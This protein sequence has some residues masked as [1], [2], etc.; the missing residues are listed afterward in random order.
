M[1]DSNIPENRSFKKIIVWSLAGLLVVGSIGYFGFFASGDGFQGLIKRFAP[2]VTTQREPVVEI[3]T[4]ETET[5]DIRS[6]SKLSRTPQIVGQ[7]CIEGKKSDL[8]VDSITLKD[9][10]ESMNHN[11][12]DYTFEVQISNVNKLTNKTGVYLSAYDKTLLDGIEK[13]DQINKGNAL[14]HI[15]VTNSGSKLI[16]DCGK[17]YT[18]EITVP[19]EKNRTNTE[20][21]F[22]IDTFNVVDEENEGS[23]SNTFSLYSNNLKAYTIGQPYNSFTLSDYTSNDGITGS[24]NAQVTSLETQSEKDIA[25]KQYRYKVGVRNSST[26]SILNYEDTYTATESLAFAKG[27]VSEDVASG[28]AVEIYDL[29]Q[30]TGTNQYAGSVEFNPEANPA[31]FLMLMKP[32]GQYIPLY[33]YVKLEAEEPV[34]STYCPVSDPF[35]LPNNYILIEPEKPLYKEVSPE[36]TI[37]VEVPVSTFN[38]CKKGSNP[39][40]ITAVKF[41]Q[42][43]S[44]DTGQSTVTYRYKMDGAG[45]WDPVVVN[46][47][48][49][50][51][52][53]NYQDIKLGTAKVLNGGN[54]SKVEVTAS[55][56]ANMK[57]SQFSIQLLETTTPV[58]FLGADDTYYQLSTDDWYYSVKAE[59]IGT[60]LVYKPE[61]GFILTWD[62]GAEKYGY[63]TSSKSDES[64]QI[65]NIGFGTPLNQTANIESVDLKITTDSPAPENIEAITEISPVTTWEK[66]Y[67]GFISIDPNETLGEAITIP[68]NGTVTIPINANIP[69]GHKVRLR[70]RINT[71]IEYD[72]KL[73]VELV[74]VNSDAPDAN[75]KKSGYYTFNQNYILYGGPLELPLSNSMIFVM[76]IAQDA[77]IPYI[78]AYISQKEPLSNYLTWVSFLNF[79]EFPIFEIRLQATI[80]IGYDREITVSPVV[81]DIIGNF[82]DPIEF[83][84]ARNEDGVGDY[85]EMTDVSVGEPLL[86]NFPAMNK[87]N[88]S[89]IVWGY[90]NTYPD[91]ESVLFK[92]IVKPITA[93]DDS[94]LEIPVYINDYDEINDPL[95]ENDYPLLT[96]LFGKEKLIQTDNNNSLMQKYLSINQIKDQEVDMNNTCFTAQ[97]HVEITEVTYTHDAHD[98]QPFQNVMLS[99]YSNTIY[100]PLQGWSPTK[101]IFTPSKPVTVYNGGS[102]CLNMKVQSPKEPLNN[103]FFDLTG[104][105][106]KV[107]DSETPAPT[108]LQ[109]NQVLSA[110]NPVKGTVSTFY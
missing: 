65:V 20:V 40:S 95:F 44:F 67:E 89:T 85:E 21:S 76:P 16:L 17:T 35:C 48:Y 22:L 84:L 55:N 97:G 78:T 66:Y 25:A 4:R 33:G 63:K 62:N 109:N 7:N 47:F 51:G 80:P 98:F 87:F 45:I 38:I 102:I 23:D 110:E 79:T 86:L 6:L 29:N 99:M 73:Q 11:S 19:V 34:T 59:A 36:S 61:Q 24:F 2:K 54:C 88:G 41:V 69:Y 26:S 46:G 93:Q 82:S 96:Y 1:A 15:Q 27:P 71:P 39:A 57:Y 94:G 90:V 104:I 60:A 43:H 81:S 103:T 100:L 12:L 10:N 53:V 13:Y 77:T 3:Q 30:L 101:A 14:A 70:M 28:E 72:G 91:V 8:A 83:K 52:E 58:F 92:Q 108:T 9:I 56:V 106:V 5:T 32:D 18:K 31:I 68:S 75:I 37:G 49:S 50:G 105:K 42:Q 74:G 64:P 107:L